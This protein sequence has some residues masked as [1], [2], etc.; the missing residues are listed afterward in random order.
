M[1]VSWLEL[2]TNTD[3]NTWKEQ[4]GVAPSLALT[5]SAWL[6][7]AENFRGVNVA[8]FHE[9][10]MENTYFSPTPMRD[11]SKDKKGY[12]IRHVRVQMGLC[13]EAHFD[14]DESLGILTFQQPNAINN[15]NSAT[16]SVSISVGSFAKDPTANVSWSNSTTRTFRD[17]SLRD[18]S[19]MG[20]GI[21]DHT[22]VS[23]YNPNPSQGE[24]AGIAFT[25]ADL[26]PV[27]E[28]ARSTFPLIEQASWKIPDDVSQVYYKIRLDYTLEWTEGTSEFFAYKTNQKTIDGYQSYWKR[29]DLTRR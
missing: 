16:S 5:T 28:L 7:T 10:K 17:F 23:T 13:K 4:D 26:P 29:L 3:K 1:P 8:L 18:E 20:K 22:W 25:G 24:L 27:P 21:L 9:K 19:P 11:D 15:D 14:F 2:F 12:Y 6:I